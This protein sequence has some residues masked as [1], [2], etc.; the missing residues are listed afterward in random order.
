MRWTIPNILTVFRLSAAPGVA[1]AFVV[2][3]RPTADW[4]ALALFILAALTDFID[5]R[6]ARIE[7]RVAGLPRGRS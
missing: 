4:A 5:G 7:D 1:L 3:A 6:L 2:F